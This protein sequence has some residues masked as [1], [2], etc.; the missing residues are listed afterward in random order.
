M[1]ALHPIA[2]LSAFF[3]M[4]ALGQKRT[5]ANNRK[6]ASRRSLRNSIWCFDQAE[7][8]FFMRHDVVFVH[9]KSAQQTFV[10]EG[11]GVKRYPVMYNDFI[12][13]GPKRDPAGIKRMTD[14]AKAL[15]AIKDKQAVFIS[16]GDHSGTHLTE[17][18]L[19]KT[20]GIN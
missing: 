10:A 20:A 13:I 16:R 9:A 15:R 5:S 18:K 17:L 11:H 1:S 3:G 7:D 4:S 19:W 2:T 6:T 8:F 12:L 14:V